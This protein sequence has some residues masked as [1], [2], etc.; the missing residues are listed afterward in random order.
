MR[1][2]AWQGR[3]LCVDRPPRS[4]ACDESHART[5]TQALHRLHPHGGPGGWRSARLC[6]LAQGQ[7]EFLVLRIAG[8]HAD[9]INVRLT[10]KAPRVG[11]GQAVRVLRDQHVRRD[12]EDAAVL[13]PPRV[14]GAHEARDAVRRRLRVLAAPQLHQVVYR[15]HGRLPPSASTDSVSA[16]LRRGA[17]ESMTASHSLHNGTGAGA[18]LCSWLGSPGCAVAL[19]LM[20]HKLDACVHVSVQPV[21]HHINAHALQSPWQAHARPSRRMQRC[22]HCRA[23][24]RAPAGGGNGTWVR[25]SAG[26][27]Q[28]NTV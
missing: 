5:G 16:L 2:R 10:H 11:D 3:C 6:V 14:L 22:M 25:A 23:S 21:K 7:G 20:L 19:T 24:A 4:T 15:G 18:L 8:S 13:A 12:A 27:A 1:A 17:A 28:V 26:A 9:C